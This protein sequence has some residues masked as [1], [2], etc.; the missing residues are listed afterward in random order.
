[1]KKNSMKNMSNIVYTLVLI[2]GIAKNFLAILLLFW[3]NMRHV[4]K[5]VVADNKIV[6]QEKLSQKIHSSNLWLLDHFF[7]LSLNQSEEEF[8]KH[9]AHDLALGHLDDCT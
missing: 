6:T 8:P 7:T 9:L 4:A 1:M 3:G 2:S 5:K